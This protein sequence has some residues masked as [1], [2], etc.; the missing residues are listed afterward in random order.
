VVRNTVEL[1]NI[2]NKL[3]HKR[4]LC[5]QLEYIYIKNLHLI[6]GNDE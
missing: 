4:T 5:I 2:V 3:D 6:K 1:I